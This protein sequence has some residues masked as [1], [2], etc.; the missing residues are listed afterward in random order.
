MR[1]PPGDGRAAP[2]RA[3]RGRV[4][5]RGDGN[6]RGGRGVDPALPN[7][8]PRWSLER[9]GGT[10]GRRPRHR[11]GGDAGPIHG[12]PAQPL[13]P[14]PDARL[15]RLGALGLLPGQWR[16]RLSRPASRRAG[17]HRVETRPR[18]SASAPGRRATVR[19]GRR[20]ALVASAGRPGGPDPHR[21]R[22]ALAALRG[23]PVSRGHWRW[24]PPRRDHSLPRGAASR[25]RPARVVFRAT[26]LR[27]A[28]HSV[29]TLRP[30]ARPQPGRR[31]PRSP[32]DGHGGLE[33]RD[34]PGGRRGQG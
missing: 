19:R 26:R 22:S 24:G 31:E 30:G 2:R 33:R 1:R 16:L 8:G 13:A 5:P 3:C 29:R 4:L 14:L 32:P 34:E 9:R 20:P 15:S 7:G 10:L 21:R 6:P 23:Q 27:T 28:G 18:A 25:G 12:H 11:P 17:A